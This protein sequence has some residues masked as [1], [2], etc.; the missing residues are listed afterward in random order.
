MRATESMLSLKGVSRVVA[1]GAILCALLLAVIGIGAKPVAAHSAGSP[2][3]YYIVCSHTIVKNVNAASYLDYLPGGL[4]IHETVMLQGTYDSQNPNY[5]CG[6]VR[7]AYYV[8]CAWNGNCT[9]NLGTEIY[10]VG[11]PGTWSGTLNGSQSQSVT[12]YGGWWSTS[13]PASFQAVGTWDAYADKRF[14]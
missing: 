2:A 9:V 10:N 7:A 8:Q 4:P 14:S 12:V 13:T 1:W 6:S 11:H 3:P 5:Y